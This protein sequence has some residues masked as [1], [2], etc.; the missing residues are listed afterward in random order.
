MKNFIRNFNVHGG[1]CGKLLIIVEWIFPNNGKYL[2]LDNKESLRGLE[3]CF[4]V[5][6]QD[7]K[8]F[9]QAS[10]V[11]GQSWYFIKGKQKSGW[12]IVEPAHVSASRSLH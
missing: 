9:S 7:W 5:G 8:S 11:G 10:K 3:S 2:P 4:K 1:K 12:A 6:E